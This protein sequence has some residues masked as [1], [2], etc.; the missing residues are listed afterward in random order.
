[1][2]TPRIKAIRGLAVVAS[3]GAAA[4]VL[5]ACGAPGAP[6]TQPSGSAAIV[7]PVKPTSPINLDILDASGDLLGTKPVFEAFKKANPD[8]V[9]SIS[10][11]TAAA[12]D[13]TGKLKAQSLGG[14]VSVTMVLGGTGVVGPAVQQNLL[15]KQYPDYQKYLP[16]LSTVFDKPRMEL[17]DLSGG[18]GLMN[19][20]G[21]SGPFIQ[22][23]PH[24]VKDVPDTPA[25]LLAWAKAHPKRFTYAQPPNSG[26]A[27]IF[28]Q[29]LPYLLHDK[30]P[31]DPVNGWA[32]TWAYLQ[33][34]N[35]YTAPY[36]SSSTIIGQQFGA[37][38][39]DLMPQI[40]GIDIVSRQN[41]T[42]PPDSGIAS[43]KNQVLL[44]DGH[45]WLIPKGVSPQTLYVDLALER[46]M[47][48]DKQQAA[49]LSAA[50][51]ELTT[52]NKKV[53]TKDA[54]SAAQA[55]IQQYGR[56]DFY[57]K[58]FSTG[59][60]VATLSASELQK[61]FDIWNEK[62]GGAAG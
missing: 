44:G 53:T 48:T 55:G 19:R 29:G 20:W 16:D 51:G 38:Q 39:L 58:A 61:A 57:P 37:G 18:Y 6:Q 47:M 56:P 17:Q 13:V 10:Y 14:S 62:I 1:M 12:T 40:V 21:P 33:E 24:V 22:Y 54:S 15:I 60:T 4:L 3:L 7:K 49:T 25:A 11:E 46:F 32:K 23:N 27:W 50:A 34:L 42:I 35:K 45:F 36:P 41:G 59:K 26:S 5:S 30:D 31:S 52:A 9:G 2:T 28:L 43:F 8:L